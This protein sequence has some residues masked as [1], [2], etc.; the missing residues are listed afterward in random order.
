[1]LL[2]LRY[3]GLTTFPIQSIRSFQSG[4]V[5]HESLK[6]SYRY[7]YL[8]NHLFPLFLCFPYDSLPFL[9]QCNFCRGPFYCVIYLFFLWRLSSFSYGFKFVEIPVFDVDFDNDTAWSTEFFQLTD[10]L[11]RRRRR[12]RWPAC[13]LQTSRQELALRKKRQYWPLSLL[14]GC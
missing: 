2:G 13:S 3:H 7:R 11:R 5:P 8:I 9:P 6:S 10:T 4:T 1:M 14:H 12:K